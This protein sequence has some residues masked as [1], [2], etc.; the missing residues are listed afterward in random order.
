MGLQHIEAY[1]ALGKPVL[2]DERNIA[3]A[4][5]TDVVLRVRGAEQVALGLKLLTDHAKAMP[6]ASNEP[7]K[8]PA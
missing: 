7:E 3:V 6:E 5:R 1:R 2:L 4:R 8:N